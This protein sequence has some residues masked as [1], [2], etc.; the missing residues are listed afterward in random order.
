MEGM[1]FVFLVAW[2]FPILVVG[3]VIYL[4]ASIREAVVRIDNRLARQPGAHPN[5]ASRG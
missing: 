5:D 2:A 1:W 3:Y 4:L